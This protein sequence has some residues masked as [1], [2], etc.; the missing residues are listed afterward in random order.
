MDDAVDEDWDD[1]PSKSELK[2]RMTEL[3]HIGEK[4]TQLSPAQLEKVAITDQ[5][6]IEAIDQAKRINARGG[7][8]RQLQ[9]IGKLMRDIDA[10]PIRQAIQDLEQ[11]SQAENQRFHRLENLR[12]TLLTQGDA[13]LETVVEQ[14]PG[15][16]RQHLRQLLRK[17][18]REVG[19]GKPQATARKI[20]RYLRALEESV[21]A[22]SSEDG[23]SS[24][25]SLESSDGVD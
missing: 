12:D 4:L 21:S 15:A 16:D 18:Q 25:D 3:Q 7:K 19:E 24:L 5:R 11:G 1:G 10:D 13:G 23:E 6:L 2:R 8:R 20:F 17:H 9:Y 22:E 14:L